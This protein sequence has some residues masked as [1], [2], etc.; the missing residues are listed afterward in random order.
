MGYPGE[1]AS[2]IAPSNWKDYV[3]FQ[4]VKACPLARGE[5]DVLRGKNTPTNED[6][7]EEGYHV[8]YPSGY[9]GWCPKAQFEAVSRP[10]DGMTFG[11]ALEVMKQGRKVTR[12]GWNNMDIWICIPL[13]DGPKEIPAMGIWGKPNAEYAEQNG[14]KVTVMP[15]ITMKTADGTIVMGWQGLQEDILSDDWQIVE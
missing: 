10:I 11:Q 6:P 13:C 1:I 14:G 5:S 8:L 15:Y 9:E 12:R 3:R 7:N 4:T 2:K